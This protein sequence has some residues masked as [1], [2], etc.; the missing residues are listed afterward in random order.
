MVKEV[1]VVDALE[2][3]AAIACGLRRHWA[4]CS[5][6]AAATAAAAA[7]IHTGGGVG[8]WVCGFLG[9]W[10]GGGGGA[11][12]GARRGTWHVSTARPPPPMHWPFARC[13]HAE[14]AIRCQGWDFAGGPQ[15]CSPPCEAQGSVEWTQ[16]TTKGS[17]TAVRIPISMFQ[18]RPDSSA[19]SRRRFLGGDAPPTPDPPGRREFRSRPPLVP[20]HPAQ[21]WCQPALNNS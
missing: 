17:K 10:L 15:G 1:R 11:G 9:G 21:V 16:V 3:F 13:R 7:H 18:R 4:A 20:Q 5:A 14:K 12:A 6:A 8:L 2:D 19:S